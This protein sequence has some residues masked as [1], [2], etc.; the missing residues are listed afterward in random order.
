[1]EPK[2]LNVAEAEKLKRKIATIKKKLARKC[3][4][5]QFSEELS[6]SR[7]SPKGFNLLEHLEDFVSEGKQLESSVAQKVLENVVPN[8]STSSRGCDISTCDK[9]KIQDKSS[10]PLDVQGCLYST[11]KLRSVTSNL[12]LVDPIKTSPEVVWKNDTQEQISTTYTPSIQPR[13]TRNAYKKQNSRGFTPI[14]SPMDV[15]VTPLDERLNKGRNFFPAFPSKVNLSLVEDFVLPKSFTTMKLEVVRR[16]K[17]FN[18][19]STSNHVIQDKKADN[20][21]SDT[22][23]Q[24]SKLIEQYVKKH[25]SACYEHPRECAQLDSSNICLARTVTKPELRTTNKKRSRE[26]C[27]VGRSSEPQPQP[28]WELDACLHGSSNCQ[29]LAVHLSEI[30]MGADGRDVAIICQRN[31]ISLWH[32]QSHWSLLQEFNTDKMKEFFFLDQPTSLLVVGVNPVGEACCVV[33]GQNLQAEYCRLSVWWKSCSL[34]VGCCSLNSDWLALA[35]SSDHWIATCCPNLANASL[36]VVSKMDPVRDVVTALSPVNGLI[37]ALVGLSSETIYIWNVSSGNLIS[38]FVSNRTL[39]VDQCLWAIAEE[40]LLFLAIA[41]VIKKCS[42]FLLL[43]VNPVAQIV[44]TVIE[45]SKK[46]RKQNNLFRR[47]AN[48]DFLVAPYGSSEVGAWDMQ[49]MELTA[50]MKSQQAITTGCY[51]ATPHQV[52]AA[53]GFVNGCVHIYVTEEKVTRDNCTVDDDRPKL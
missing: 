4:K 12:K 7:A 28:S 44:A 47:A 21:S 25:T 17:S 3:R 8:P 36:N 27:G 29:I 10:L 14:C 39:G 37:S 20:E 13:V 40:G 43:V 31:K 32:K 2:T 23:N 38:K 33:L 24:G 6:R 34:L 1:M 11:P 30:K 49:N 48:K 26:A 35:G 18:M 9:N 15:I 52:M 5:L 19:Y 22:Q 51:I 45:Q 53:F 16:G 41:S 50:L 46:L 42:I